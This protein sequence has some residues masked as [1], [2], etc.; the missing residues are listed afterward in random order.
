MKFFVS[1]LLVALLSFAAALYLPWW[2]IAVAGFIVAICISQPPLHAFWS[3]FLGGFLLW[4]GLAAWMS[5][6]NDNILAGRMSLLILKVEEPLLLILVTGL[7]G[8]LV[9]GL[10]SLSASLLVKKKS[11]DQQK[12]SSEEA[13]M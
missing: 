10:S 9:A 5:F 7:I 6:N 3:G 2:I 13:A 12:I 1:I 4:G 8:G 11:I